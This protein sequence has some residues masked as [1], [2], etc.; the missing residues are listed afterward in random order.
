MYEL[1]TIEMSLRP[2]KFN[3]IPRWQGRAA[4]A[5]FYATL[6]RIHPMVSETIHDLHKWHPHLPKP[7]TM[8]SI[9]GAPVV[10][11]F[12]ELKPSETIQL[13]LTT[14]HPHLTSV[15]QHGVLPIWLQEDFSLH[16]QYLRVLK[17]TRHTRLNY[18][19]ILRRASDNP[20][21]IL[22][23]TSPT[24]FKKT[25]GYY[26]AKPDV[27]LIFMSL[28]NRWNAFA[29]CKLPDALRETIQKRIR[30]ITAGINQ[31]TLSFARGRKGVI[32]GFL[33][34]VQF[35]LDEPSPPLRH[36]INALAAFASFSGV[37]IKTTIGMGQVC[38]A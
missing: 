25:Q 19:D 11:D 18:I 2:R 37:G 12:I 7:F 4:Q 28:F 21:I 20:Q 9:V 38:I 13:R 36:M 8:S 29:H 33:G 24:A 14:L 22:N 10:D 30:V 26:Y 34:E 35:V 17:I 23:F 27:E 15:V 31:D 16:D 32:P 3:H 1:M 5:L 6:H